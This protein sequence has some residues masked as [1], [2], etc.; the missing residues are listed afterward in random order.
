M[1]FVYNGVQ[2]IL[3][4]FTVPLSYNETMNSL[5]SYAA[6]ALLALGTAHCGAAVAPGDSDAGAPVDSGAIAEQ[7]AGPVVAPSPSCEEVR[8]GCGPSP[9]QFIRGHADG[10]TGLDGAR[11]EFAVRYAGVGQ[12][13]SQ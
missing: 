4:F 13:L 1:E 10:L 6:L 3:I 8:A 7:D 5:T 11:V 9:Q 12:D 2:K